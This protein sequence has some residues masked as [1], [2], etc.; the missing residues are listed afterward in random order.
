MMLGPFLSR[1][2]WGPGGTRCLEAI[3]L[4]GLLS[5][6]LYP[7][8]CIFQ[9]WMQWLLETDLSA[10]WFGSASGARSHVWHGPI[11]FSSNK[12]A[13]LIENV[14]LHVSLVVWMWGQIHVLICKEKT[15]NK[16]LRNQLSVG[17]AW[18]LFSV[19][20]LLPIFIAAY[21]IFL[22]HM[23]YMRNRY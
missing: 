15:S 14:F 9:M 23:K 3:R 18:C 7:V 16:G 13:V 1:C 21:W 19:S 2:W 20:M 5:W 17:R 4:Y 10:V 11:L 8:L 12:R 6:C 22:N